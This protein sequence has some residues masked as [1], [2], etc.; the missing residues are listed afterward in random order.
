MSLN[1]Q[2]NLLFLSA[3]DDETNVSDKTDSKKTIDGLAVDKEL[4]KKLAAEFVGTYLLATVIAGGGDGL[5]IGAILTAMT[6]TLKSISGGYFNPAF[7]FGSLISSLLSNKDS[8]IKTFKLTLAYTATQFTAVLIAAAAETAMTKDTNNATITVPS[9]KQ[10]LDWTSVF[11]TEMLFTF[12]CVLT[13]LTNSQKSIT[14]Y[15][16]SLG[17][18]VAVGAHITGT[19]FN[20]AMSIVLPAVAGN[21]IEWELIVGPYAGAALAAGFYKIIDWTEEK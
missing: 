9:S 15:G 20:P 14:H 2:T 3:E 1:E 19:V 12:T 4:A 17:L 21:N 16:L 18:I 5:L 8:K 11:F 13:M 10:G 7:T 6:F